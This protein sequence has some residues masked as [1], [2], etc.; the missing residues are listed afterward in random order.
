MD[1]TCELTPCCVPLA[2]AATAPT[3]VVTVDVTQVIAD[4]QHNLE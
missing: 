4:A 2:L 1:H 3:T